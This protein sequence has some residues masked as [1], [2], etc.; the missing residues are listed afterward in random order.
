MERKSHTETQKKSAATGVNSSGLSWRYLMTVQDKVLSVSSS[1]R[2]VVQADDHRE[3]ICCWRCTCVPSNGIKR[4]SGI[5]LP[6]ICSP[7]PPLRLFFWWRQGTGDSSLSRSPLPTPFFFWC[8]AAGGLAHTPLNKPV[9]NT[10]LFSLLDCGQYVSSPCD[11]SGS[12]WSRTQSD[13]CMSK[14]GRKTCFCYSKV[15]FFFISFFL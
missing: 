11:E 9:H 10:S 8:W 15:C 6:G 5:G 7:P 14:R 12:L 2:G 13:T 3:K 1:E 4:M